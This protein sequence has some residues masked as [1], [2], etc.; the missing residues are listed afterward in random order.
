MPPAPP[1]VAPEDE[2]PEEDEEEAPDD[3]APDPEEDAPLVPLLVPDAPLDDPPS[4]TGPLTSLP[5]E[6]PHAQMRIPT[7][8]KKAVFRMATSHCTL[9]QRTN[10]SQ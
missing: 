5:V 6:P 2:A 9:L 10:R 7:H 4:G 1:S 3:D 8:A